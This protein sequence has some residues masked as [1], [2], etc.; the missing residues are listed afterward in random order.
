MSMIR[1]IRRTMKRAA[2]EKQRLKTLMLCLKP[3]LKR[4]TA[5]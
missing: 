2:Y 4:R 5:A 3:F 1:T